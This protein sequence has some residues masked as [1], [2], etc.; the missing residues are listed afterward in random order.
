MPKRFQ[1]GGQAAGTF[2]AR[3]SKTRGAYTIDPQYRQA[4]FWSTL[5]FSFNRWKLFERDNSGQ[6]VKGGEITDSLPAAL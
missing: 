5:N 3:K 2:L 6:V 4:F 1:R